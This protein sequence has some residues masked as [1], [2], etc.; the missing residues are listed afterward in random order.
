MQIEYGAT[1]RERA[2]R[3]K[4]NKSIT[5]PVESSGP[6]I[7][8]KQQQDG[9]MKQNLSHISPYTNLVTITFQLAKR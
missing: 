3:F 6:I 1:L 7:H 2:R 5:N 4:G 9:D 8:Q